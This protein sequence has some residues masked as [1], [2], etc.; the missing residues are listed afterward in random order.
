MAGLRLLQFLPGAV[1]ASV[2][3]REAVRSLGAFVRALAN[4]AIDE[5]A[6]P[7]LAAMRP[8]GYFLQTLISSEWLGETVFAVVSSFEPPAIGEGEITG[9]PNQMLLALADGL[10]DQLLGSDNDLVVNPASMTDFGP[11]A[12]IRIAEL[13]DLVRPH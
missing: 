4:R 3:G 8:Q 6:V 10:I 13:L 1:T 2:I 9:L 11:G 12:T 5:D 7:G